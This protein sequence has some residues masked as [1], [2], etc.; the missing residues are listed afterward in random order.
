MNEKRIKESNKSLWKQWTLLHIK[1]SFYDVNGFKRGQNALKHI[2][3]S[4][5]GD[6]KGKSMLHLQCHFGID[7][8]CWSRLGAKVTGVDFCEE[9][10]AF[11]RQLSDELKLDAKFVVS[12]IYELNDELLSHEKFDIVFTSYGVIDWLPDLD[13]WAQ[14]ISRS[15]KS[16]GLFYIAE[17][18]PLIR[19]FDDCCEK[20][21]YDYGDQ[22]MF[23][24][25]V[26]GSYAVKDSCIKAKEYT[27]N[28]SI[29][30]VIN[31]LIKNGLI[32]EFYNEHMASPYSI[33][34]NCVSDGHNNWYI[35]GFE[36]KIPLVFSLMARKAA[37]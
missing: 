1:S 11:A 34:D 31:S 15:L 16:N 8:L 4:E 21:V 13:R 22:K 24:V 12:D 10:I 19:N 37:A 5:L 17:F 30:E 25:E 29:S 3:L 35:R 18:H 14:I 27:W 20:M 7:S 6:V 26:Q 28:H 32:I 2:E 9:A 23:E 33:C 36:R